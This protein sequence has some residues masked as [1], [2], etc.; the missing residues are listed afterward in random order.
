MVKLLI[1]VRRVVLTIGAVTSLLACGGRSIDLVGIEVAAGGSAGAASTTTGGAGKVAATGGVGAIAAGGSQTS[2][3]FGPQ[4]TG[5][6]TSNSSDAG[7]CVVHDLSI[8]STDGCAELARL[9]LRDAR[10]TGPTTSNRIMPGDTVS[11]SLTVSDASGLGY[12]MYPGAVFASDVSGVTFDQGGHSFN[13]YALLGCQSVEASTTVHI[14]GNLAPGT[15][16]NVTA[17]AASVNVDC[18]GAPA[19]VI[20]I[21]VS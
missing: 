18:P 12:N 10:V 1:D 8:L 4:A 9:V 15:V 5:G 20:P 11:I 6:S 2:G 13:A 3:G 21:T 17:R 19:I 7:T 16:V 14:P